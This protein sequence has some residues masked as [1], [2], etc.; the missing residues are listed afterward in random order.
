MTSLCAPTPVTTNLERRFITSVCESRGV[1]TE[2]GMVAFDPST[3]DCYMLQYPDTPL[4]VRTMQQLNIYTSNQTLIPDTS[5]NNKIDMFIK[6]NTGSAPLFVPRKFYNDMSGLQY[7]RQYGIKMKGNTMNLESKYYCLSALS[8][9]FKTLE[10]HNEVFFASH[11]IRFQY[12]VCEDVMMLDYNVSRDL[13]LVKSLDSKNGI[14]LYSMLNKCYT[15]MG[16]R[17]LRMMILQPSKDPMWIN[18]RLNCLEDLLM[19]QEQFNFVNE[20]LNGMIDIDKLIGAFIKKDKRNSVKQAERNIN[21]LL[22]LK[23]FLVQIFNLSHLLQGCNLNIDLENILNNLKT[24]NLKDLYEIIN[25]IV[26]EEVRFERGGIN[27]RNQRVYAIKAGNNGLLDV[28]RIAYKE[29]TD[30]VYNLIK[31]YSEE[32]GIEL[33]INFSFNCYQISVPLRYE[34]ENIPDLFLNFQKKK[35]EFIC[36]TIELIKLNERINE[37]LNEIYLI[38]NQIISQVFEQVYKYIEDLYLVSESIAIIDTLQSLANYAISNDCVRPNFCN[39]LALKDCKHPL[40]SYSNP[41]FIPNQVY[42]NDNLNFHIIT[43]PNMSG[44]S[45]YIRQIALLQILSQIGSFVPCKSAHFKIMDKIFTR[46]CNDDNSKS[47]TSTFMMEMTETSFILENLSENSLIIMDELGRGTSLRDGTAIAFS[48]CNHLIKKRCFSFFVTHFL[49]VAE[50]LSLYPN[51][52]SFHLKSQLTENNSFK[53]Y[54]E[55]QM[56][57]N[58]LKDYGLVLARNCNLPIPLINYS[59]KVLNIVTQYPFNHLAK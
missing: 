19:N 44:K 7:V 21:N 5:D 17:L 27:A 47:N 42:A 45:T 23:S 24:D 49:Q 31:K 34:K 36:T 54:Y 37:S 41:L 53:F 48:I 55:M 52:N 9:L 1:A 43:G 4:Y 32:F 58:E 20:A 10:E 22:M 29:I 59:N 13:E 14:S 57:L 6:E 2:V 50:S 35:K 51:V 26:N 18:G 3:C 11:T 56:G 28:A 39:I 15:G 30:D 25:G 8:A 40:K 38:S 16:R 46:L 33:K 12:R